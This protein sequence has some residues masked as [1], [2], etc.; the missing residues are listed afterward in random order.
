MRVSAYTARDFSMNGRGV[1]A[2]G[3][4]VQEGVTIAAPKSIPFG[5]RIYIPALNHEYVVEDRG[6]AIK[7]DKLDLYMDSREKALEFGV[8][9]LVVY[10]VEK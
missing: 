1:T 6:G 3:E 8:K 4:H 2:N 7:R 9:W 5:T 10:I